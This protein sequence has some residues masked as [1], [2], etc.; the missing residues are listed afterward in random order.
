MHDGKYLTFGRSA[1]I[2]ARTCSHERKYNWSVQT[3]HVA[4]YV[5]TWNRRELEGG[6]VEEGT[7][8]I[9][10]RMMWRNIHKQWNKLTNFVVARNVNYH[11]YFI[12][13]RKV[14][15]KEKK[16]KEKKIP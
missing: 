12:A 16:K 9:R 15:G 10:A 5:Y 3:K 13:L 1:C 2:N 14:E 6:G 7:G 11:Y 8:N 4:A